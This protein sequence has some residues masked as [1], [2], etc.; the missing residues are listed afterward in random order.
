MALTLDPE[1]FPASALFSIGS[2]ELGALDAILAAD[3]RGELAEP[4]AEL[5][6]GLAALE[7]LGAKGEPIGESA[8][9][10]A[11]DGWRSS[12]GLE[13]AEETEAWLAAREIEIDDVA[14]FLERRIAAK[15]EPFALGDDV[16]PD[17][18]SSALYASLVS[19]GAFDALL[20]AL[21]R[22]AA[23]YAVWVEGGKKAPDPAAVA[24]RAAQFMPSL[25]ARHARHERL[26][27][28]ESVFDL[29]VRASLDPERLARAVEAARLDLLRL[30]FVSV[31]FE[32]LDAAREAVFC[33]E[34][35]HEDIAR[36]ARRAGA[37]L[38]HRLAFAGEL[39][40][41]VR[42]ALLSTRA[43]RLAGPFEEGGRFVLLEL[44]RKIE[45]LPEDPE[46]RARIAARVR[47]RAFRD[48]MESRVRWI[49]WQPS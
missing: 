41:A 28:M 9:Q 13:S 40:E 24:E 34:D 2:D 15:R 5:K 14:A 47:D 20:V 12:H 25:L 21:A 43:S 11:V 1:D 37:S 38:T 16:D 22:R 33:V 31:S 10:D 23:A 19:S 45:P 8:L 30:D 29:G 49:A 39:D 7:R 17:D 32:T 48:D 44:A 26:A 3:L 18:I 36:V 46:V 27:E 6:K 4:V 35:D 42:G